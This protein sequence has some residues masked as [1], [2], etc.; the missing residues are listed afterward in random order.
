MPDSSVS[1]CRDTFFFQLFHLISLVFSDPGAIPPL[2]TIIIDFVASD[3]VLLPQETLFFSC[4][5]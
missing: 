5:S 2:S 1:F 3:P 4:P